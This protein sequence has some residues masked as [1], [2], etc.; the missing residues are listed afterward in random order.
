MKRLPSRITPHALLETLVEVHYT[1]LSYPEVAFGAFYEAL[2]ADYRY[3]RSLSQAVLEVPGLA[4]QAAGESLFLGHGPREG[5]LFRLRPASIAFNCSGDYVGWNRYFPLI[6]D[7]LQRL[8]ATE[9]IT[10]YP[11]VGVRYVNALPSESL[12]DQL[13]TPLPAL[14]PAPYVEPGIPAPTSTVYRA[15]L[16]DPA[17]FRVVL[18][19]ADQQPVPGHPDLRS[20]FDVDVILEDQPTADLSTLFDQIDRTHTREKEVFFGLLH[21]TYLASLH[22]EY[23]EPIA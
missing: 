3:E 18:Q 6:Q 17:G 22:P 2:K 9:Q 19:L 21:P 15:T 20:I 16:A 11:R 4:V 10:G 23:D 7:V 12:N 5:I 1:A 13:H 14:L 8:H